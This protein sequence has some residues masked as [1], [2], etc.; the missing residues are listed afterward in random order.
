M[1]ELANAIQAERRRQACRYRM[2]ASLPKERT[3]SLGRY[4]ITVARD[5][6]R[7]PG[8]A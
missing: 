1:I 3:M 8:T 2:A 4:R 6:S 7:A 5:S